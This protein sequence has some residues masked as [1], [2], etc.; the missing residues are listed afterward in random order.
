MVARCPKEESRDAEQLSIAGAFGVCQ[1][2]LEF[3]LQ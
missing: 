3:S 1:K 2:P